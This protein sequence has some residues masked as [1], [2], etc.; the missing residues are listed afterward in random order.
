MLDI[1]DKTKV[2]ER[3]VISKD[4]Y[5][6]FTEE[7]LREMSYCDEL[8]DLYYDRFG[9][10]IG[11]PFGHWASESWGQQE[12][13]RELEIALETDTPFTPGTPRYDDIFGPKIE[14]PEDCVI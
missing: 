10:R 2:Q 3:F 7:Q 11:I 1:I 4:R 6:S 8:E 12:F 14:L 13:I 9:S 5:P